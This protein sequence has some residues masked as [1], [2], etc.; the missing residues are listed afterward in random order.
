M[1]FTYFLTDNYVPVEFLELIERFVRW[2][3]EVGD[4]ELK[5]IAYTG[6]NMRAC[7]PPRQPLYKVSFEIFRPYS[8]TV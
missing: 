5:C 8:N 4:W 1:N 3:E 6:N 7:N 2:N